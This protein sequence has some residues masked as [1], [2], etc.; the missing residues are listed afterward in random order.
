MKVPFSP[1]ELGPF[2]KENSLLPKGVVFFTWECFLLHRE[3]AWD[4]HLIFLW[5]RKLLP[6]GNQLQKLLK[7][8]MDFFIHFIY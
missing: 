1:K 3:L 2:L 7:Y 8:S 6:K 4:W 5:L